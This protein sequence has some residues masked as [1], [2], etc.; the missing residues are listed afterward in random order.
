M[1]MF[2]S[3]LVMLCL[4]G[5]SG[6]CNTTTAAAMRLMCCKD[7]CCEKTC[8]GNKCPCDRCPSEKKTKLATALLPI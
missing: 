7:K 2:S 4:F 3:V 5:L 1:K 6:C 8:I